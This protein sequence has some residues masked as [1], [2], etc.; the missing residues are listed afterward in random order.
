MYIP[1]A[2]YAVSQDNPHYYGRISSRCTRECAGV[3]VTRKRAR[4]RSV[5]LLLLAS[6]MPRKRINLG[7]RLD[8]PMRWLLA[9]AG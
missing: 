7:A 1:A 8:R 3:D 5:A 6:G 2:L 4:T 9:A